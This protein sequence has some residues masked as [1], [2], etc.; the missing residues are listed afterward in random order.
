MVVPCSCVSQ[1]GLKPYYLVE[2]NIASLNRVDNNSRDK[3]FYLHIEVRNS[4]VS[5]PV[6]VEDSLFVDIFGANWLER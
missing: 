6:L 4:L 5:L 1:L 3:F 2:M